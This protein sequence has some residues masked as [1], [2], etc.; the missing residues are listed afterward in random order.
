MSA[1]ID[2][3]QYEQEFTNQGL[4]FE[5]GEDGPNKIYTPHRHGW[6][7]LVTR[8]GSITMKLEGGEPFEQRAGDVCEVGS[9]QLHEAVV[10]P[11]GWKWLAA[12]KPE[13]GDTFNVHES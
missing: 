11:D 4:I 9:G 12:W 5:Y 8:A 6:T 1:R 7:K 13:E 3:E 10:G 2:T